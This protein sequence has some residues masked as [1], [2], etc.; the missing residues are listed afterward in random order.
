MYSL[1]EIEEVFKEGIHYTLS[2]NRCGVVV[3]Y[4]LMIAYFPFPLSAC[5]NGT[6]KDRNL[7]YISGTIN[8]GKCPVEGSLGNIFSFCHVGLKISGVTPVFALARFPFGEG[9]FAFVD[10]NDGWI[11]KVLL[12][13]RASTSGLREIRMG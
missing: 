13:G 9:I 3:G 5:F 6:I 11:W 8:D 1:K 2:G 4:L 7:G 10:S 12:S